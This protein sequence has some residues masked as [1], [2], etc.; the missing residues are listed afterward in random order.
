M[1]IMAV[2]EGD[3]SCQTMNCVNAATYGMFGA[4][5][6][7]GGGGIEPGLWEGESRGYKPIVCIC[8]KFVYKVFFMWMEEHYFIWDFC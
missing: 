4:F 1:R 2:V 5:T 6:Y 8:I 7:I 3:V